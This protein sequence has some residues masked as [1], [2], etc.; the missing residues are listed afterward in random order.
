[1]SVPI[2]NA[3]KVTETVSILRQRIGER[4][5]DTG[6]FN[7]CKTLE[8]LAKQTDERTEQFSQPI[9][10]VRVLCWIA[11][12]LITLLGLVLPFVVKIANE[13]GITVFDWQTLSIYRPPC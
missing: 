7:I 2:L 6:L 3:A 8:D 13:H 10:W 1:M 5:P 12:G 4:F 11:V 9:M